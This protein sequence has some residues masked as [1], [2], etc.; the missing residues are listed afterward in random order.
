[1]NYLLRNCQIVNENEIFS[2]SIRIIGG[3]IA[4]IE[5]DGGNKET[6]SPSFDDV[7]FYEIDLQGKLL[8]PGVIDDQV[9]FRDPGLTYK[10]DIYTESKA[11]AAGGIT[12]FMDMPNTV[13]NAITR[14][15]LE[16]KYKLAS[17]KSLINYSFFI[18]ASN[19]NLD[20]LLSVDPSD[21]CGIKV[22]MGSST[23]NMLVDREESLKNIFSQ[24]NLLVAV[25]AED[26][27]IVRNNMASF[28]EKYGENIPIQCHPMIRNEEACFKSSSKAVELATKHGAR[29]H[30]LHLST[31]KELSL[32]SNKLPI[33]Q[34]QITAE[35]CV[36]HLWF[37]D[38]DY[39]K[40]G[41]YIK[42]NPA[43]K[44]EEDRE[45]LF[46]AVL[47]NTIDIIAT[48]HAPHTREEKQQTYLKAPSGG[49]LVQH[50]LPMMLD[51]YNK[52]E[53]SLEKIV[54]KMSHHP[55]ML[56]RIKERGFIRE[57]Y[58]ADLCIVDPKSAWE[59]KNDNILYKCGWSPLIGHKF[60][61]RITHTFVNGELVFENGKFIE[62]SR[63]KRLTFKVNEI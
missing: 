57:G 22:F 61:S 31:A 34:K 39:D 44:K 47:N 8:L 6:I 11:A 28:K 25:H 59:V 24:K 30:I 12:S 4:S 15:T 37:N 32:L 38:S 50:S 3:R 63:G 23:G 33:G 46:Q 19:N 41:N 1:M 29:L 27:N 21:V 51:F 62:T 20:E 48:D 53:I 54:E 2:G 43:I 40:F 55:A 45:S 36:H 13:P 5:R 49:P 17:E 16:E 9:H 18:G 10:G 26:E 52:K 56:Y 35:V 60:S 14:E 58:W 42:W 7:H